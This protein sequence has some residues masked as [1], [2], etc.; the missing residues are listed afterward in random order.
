MQLCVWVCIPT[1]TYF[2]RICSF[3]VQIQVFKV[4]L[5]EVGMGSRLI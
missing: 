4:R 1:A 5:I 2:G 3:N